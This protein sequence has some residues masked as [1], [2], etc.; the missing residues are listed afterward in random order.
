MNLWAKFKAV[1]SGFSLSMRHA[2]HGRLAAFALALTFFATVLPAG[3]NIQLVFEGIA[4]PKRDTIY[5]NVFGEEFVDRKSVFIYWE[6]FGRSLAVVVASLLLAAG[7]RNPA[8]F[9]ISLWIWSSILMTIT[10]VLSAL[11]EGYEVNM[12]L[13]IVSNFSGIA[14]LS[15][16]GAIIYFLVEGYGRQEGIYGLFANAALGVIFGS[17]FVALIS[18]ANSTFLSPQTQYLRATISDPHAVFSITDGLDNDV[19]RKFMGLRPRGDFVNEATA[20]VGGPVV[21]TLGSEQPNNAYDLDLYFAKDCGLNW[22]GEQLPAEPVASFK[23]VRNFKLSVDNLSQVELRFAE[24]TSLQADIEEGLFSWMP[25][26]T[27]RELSQFAFETLRPVN[28]DFGRPA[29]FSAQISTAVV[30]LDLEGNVS[31]EERTFA[32]EVDGRKFKYVS[33][34]EEPFVED[35]NATCSFD[36]SENNT[37]KVDAS[38]FIRVS[39]RDNPLYM[40]SEG[41]SMLVEAGRGQFWLDSRSFEKFDDELLGSASEI[42]IYDGIKDL[43][44]GGRRIEIGEGH[45]VLFGAGDLVLS[46]YGETQFVLEGPAERVY[47]DNV[48]LNET[49]WES[50]SDE[51]KV[52]IVGGLAALFIG[53]LKIGHGFLRARFSDEF[54]N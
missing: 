45:P 48:R 17:I 6:V 18:F 3:G 14:V 20:F 30:D 8:N 23:E 29:N 46:A 11:V 36:R 16:I 52:W 1:L 10:D 9:F 32:L 12:L 2:H 44:L 24:G 50:L 19:R 33:R 25:R 5:S 15:A 31:F 7:A 13:A 42:Q 27:E 38:V 21:M 39:S 54:S 37:A 41:R 22:I 28:L 35:A 4:L 49:R 47:L 40:G 51:W 43:Q 53:L 26:K 34:P